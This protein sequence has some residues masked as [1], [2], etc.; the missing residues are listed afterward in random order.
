[1]LRVPSGNGR[2]TLAG[3]GLKVSQT[4]AE[5]TNPFFPPPPPHPRWGCSGSL[6]CGAPQLHRAAVS[7]EP[8]STDFPPEGAAI[9]RLVVP[10][11]GYCRTLKTKTPFL[12]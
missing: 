6:C 8:L 3:F 1:M 11:I 12:P 5:K 2:A 4:R 10:A 7:A 9:S